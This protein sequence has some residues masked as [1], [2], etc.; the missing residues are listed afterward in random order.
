MGKLTRCGLPLWST[1]ALLEAPFLPVRLFKEFELRSVS[2]S[3]V[4]RTLS[5]SGTTAQRVSRIHLDRQ[6]AQVQTRV[7]SAIVRDLLGPRRRPMLIVDCRE[8]TRR[9]QTFSARSAGILGFSMF[10][11]DLTYALDENMELRR[12]AVESFCRTHAREDLLVFGF[13]SIIFQ[14]LIQPLL[15]SGRSLP[16][17]RATLIHGGGW[18]RLERMALDRATYHEMLGRVAGIQRVVNYYGMAEQTGSIFPECPAGHLH[19][20]IYSDVMVRSSTFEPCAV[21]EAGLIQLISLLPESYPGHVILTED[22]GTVL[23]EDDCACG[24]YGKYFSVQGRATMAEMRGCSDTYSAP[25]E[26]L[27]L[28]EPEAARTQPPS[29]L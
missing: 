3:A 22:L 8:A 29:A 27:L 24:R 5:S 1:H 28:G 7:L 9:S 20:S 13:T 11:R 25:T 21:G 12:D 19:A 2:A 17:E 18:K 15:A 6:T 14:H 16:L 10:G 4:Q 23:G 26:H